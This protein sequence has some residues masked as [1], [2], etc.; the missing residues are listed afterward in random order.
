MIRAYDNYAK[1]KVWNS[2]KMFNKNIVLNI[3]YICVVVKEE[4][5]K[6]LKFGK[7]L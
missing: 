3:S 4:I 1:I 6:R 2:K 5:K 7:S